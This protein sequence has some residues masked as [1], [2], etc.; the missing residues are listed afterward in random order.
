MYP[1]Y[2]QVPRYVADY[3]YT[4]TA[5]PEKRPG[6]FASAIK[7]LSPCQQDIVPQI[8][9]I[10]F[11]ITPVGVQSQIWVNPRSKHQTPLYI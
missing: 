4:P 8:P 7:I 10:L 1:R 9:L 11:H 5:G 2:R 3:Y 6:F